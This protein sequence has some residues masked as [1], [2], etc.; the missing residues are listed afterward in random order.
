M[1]TVDLIRLER[2]G[3]LRIDEDVEPDFTLW[4]EGDVEL[5]GP[6]RVRLEARRAGRGDLLVE[7]RISAEI[8]IDCRR[9]LEPVRQ[10][11][12]EEVS[13]FF[14][15]GIDPV[16]AEREEVFPLPVGENEVD[17]TEAIREHLLLSVPRLVECRA[18]CRGLCPRCGIDLNE[19]TC[20][21]EDS[22]PDPRWAPFREL[23]LD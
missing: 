23:K 18:D 2:Q 5:D 9:C 10:Q 11:I 3:R 7:G 21:C 20:S 12:D 4:E 16:T 19:G 1:L 14:R 17:L 22:E 6:L 13:F 15:A 8:V